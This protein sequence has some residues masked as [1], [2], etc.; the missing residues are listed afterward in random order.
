MEE[1]QIQE[2]KTHHCSLMPIHTFIFLCYK[3]SKG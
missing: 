3:I 1:K 2:R